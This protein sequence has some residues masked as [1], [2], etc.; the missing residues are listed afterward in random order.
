MVLPRASLSVKNIVIKRAH[1]GQNI[2][3][4]LYNLRMR[5][6]YT[7]VHI[8]IRG[9]NQ[10]RYVASKGFQPNLMYTCSFLTLLDYTITT[11]CLSPTLLV[12]P[13]MGPSGLNSCKHKQIKFVG[14]Q[15][16]LM[17]N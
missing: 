2:L 1:W 3:L 11:H 14:F 17:Y 5:G 10:L 8:W 15:Q 6:R 12:E 13:L 16:N 4:L 9:F 7:H